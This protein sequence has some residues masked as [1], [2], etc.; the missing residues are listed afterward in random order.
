MIRKRKRANLVLPLTSFG[1]IAFLM[2]IF[3]M[4]ASNFM[5]SANIELTDAA[6]SSIEVQEA[7]QISVTLDQDGT[8]WCD[9]TICTPTELV[10]LLQFRTESQPGTPVHLRIDASQPRSSFM[11]VIEA[12]SEAGTKLILTGKLEE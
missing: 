6:S 12:V 9:G 11:P 7:P 10:G 5:K 4:L 1:D 8:L 2:I 3:F